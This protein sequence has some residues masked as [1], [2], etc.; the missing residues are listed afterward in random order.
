MAPKKPMQEPRELTVVDVSA[1]RIRR[2]QIAP[3]WRRTH[4]A[5]P[6]MTGGIFAVNGLR[7]GRLEVLA[8]WKFNLDDTVL[9]GA[10]TCWS[11]AVLHV[12]CDG[13]RV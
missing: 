9:L 8:L 2:L 5:I 13:E 7:V 1:T 6:A 10:G 3:G 4:G 12:E 11:F